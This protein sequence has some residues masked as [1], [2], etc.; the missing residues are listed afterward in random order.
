MMARERNRD[1]ENG[2]APSKEEFE[3]EQEMKQEM[4]QDDM[5]KD[6]QML[7]SDEE[8]EEKK[9]RRV[10]V[11]GE[12]IATGINFLPGENAKRDGKDIISLRFGLED[13]SGRIAK[14]IPL[15]GVYLPRRGNIVIGKITDITFNGWLIDINCS[16]PAFLPLS[17]CQGFVSKKEDLSAIYNFDNLIVAKVI[18]VKAKGVDLTMR[19]RGLSKLSDGI[20]MLVNSNKVPR[21]IGRKGSMVSMIKDYTKCDIVVGQN[22]MIWIQG[23][24]LKNEL[25][26]KET[27]QMIT[28]KSVSVG[29][30]EHVQEFLENAQ[31]T[32][33]KKESK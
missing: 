32:K 33:E 2:H 16:Y 22:G 10:V 25:L 30:T 27:I 26:A 31:K 17:E 18:S 21:I 13:I 11:P 3:E 12:V 24:D 1:E 23:Q 8:F 5:N 29:L 7:Q 6:T 9:E 15:S 4:R 20:T 28:E 14:V 19:D